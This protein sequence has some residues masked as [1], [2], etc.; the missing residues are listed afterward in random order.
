MELNPADAFKM[1]LALILK[2][3][4]VDRALTTRVRVARR[5]GRVD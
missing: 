1:G 5:G 3:L 4:E 2:A